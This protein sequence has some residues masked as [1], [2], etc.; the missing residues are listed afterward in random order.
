MLALE[1]CLL[2]RLLTLFLL[3]I[4]VFK[5]STIYCF[6]SGVVKKTNEILFRFL[7]DMVPYGK[8]TIR[9]LRRS[10][11]FLMHATRRVAKGQKPIIAQTFF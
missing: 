5:L 9:C 10:S 1:G 8:V 7:G 11:N 3:E 6:L 2:S 4:Q